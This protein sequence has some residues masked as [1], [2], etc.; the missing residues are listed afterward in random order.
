MT[1]KASL[2]VYFMPQISLA[3]FGQKS[4]NFLQKSHFSIEYDHFSLHFPHFFAPF[5]IEKHLLSYVLT[6]RVMT[7]DA[8]Q[9]TSL[10]EHDR[11]CSPPVN[12]ASL[13][14]KNHSFHSLSYHLLIM[15]SMFGMLRFT[16]GWFFLQYHPVKRYLNSRS[17]RKSLKL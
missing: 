16:F 6:L 1:V 12:G 10:K 5:L 7:S 8:P 17:N 9:I 11:A 3:S 4:A 2:T 15:T 14:I 13:Y